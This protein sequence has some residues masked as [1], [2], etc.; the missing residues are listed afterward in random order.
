MFFPSC[1]AIQILDDR[2]GFL[3]NPIV[4]EAAKRGIHFAQPTVSGAIVLV[5]QMLPTVPINQ[6]SFQ[7]VKS[8]T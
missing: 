5:V 4:P 3:Q 2:I 8:G 1:N 7:T 6:R